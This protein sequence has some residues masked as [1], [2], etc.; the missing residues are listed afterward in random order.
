MK[1]TVKEAFK[2]KQIRN[3]NKNIEHIALNW[4]QNS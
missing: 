4:F 2:K 3:L 1:Y